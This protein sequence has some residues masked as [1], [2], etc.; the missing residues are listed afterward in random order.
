MNP[1]HLL[2]ALFVSLLPTL[3][4]AEDDHTACGLN[5]S[6]AE[7]ACGVNCLYVCLRLLEVPVTYSNLVATLP[8]MLGGVSVA[9]IERCARSKGL[10]VKTL[11]L[12]LNE[13]LKL[14][15]PA[16]CMGNVGSKDGSLMA[17]N[18]FFEHAE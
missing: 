5:E 6:Q 10:E 3:V 17:T 16:I 1:Q 14:K 8:P 13:I 2:P 11:K 15:T 9:E 18:H 12:S 7:E 4:V